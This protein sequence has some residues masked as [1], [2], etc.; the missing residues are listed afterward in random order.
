M[1]GRLLT[2]CVSAAALFGGVIAASAQEHT[3]RIQTHYGPETLSGQL[4]AQ[5]VDDVETMSGGRVDIEM[6]FSSSVVKL[7]QPQGCRAAG[8][9]AARR[10]GPAYRQPG[11][12]S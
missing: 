12:S 3:L 9:L 8:S 11:A 4:A 1:N 6:F 10:S 5:F 2:A 7:V